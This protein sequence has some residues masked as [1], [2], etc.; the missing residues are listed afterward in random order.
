MKNIVALETFTL[1]MFNIFH[2]ACS[3][4]FWEDTT[5]VARGQLGQPGVRTIWGSALA[6]R[7]GGDGLK[8]LQRRVGWDVR[9][10]L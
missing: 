8:L 1:E 3:S 7:T 2:F 6:F 10:K 4:F 9:R 5:D